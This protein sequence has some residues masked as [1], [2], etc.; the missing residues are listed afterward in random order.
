MKKII[1]YLVGLIGLF[2]VAFGIYN[3]FAS[4]LDTELLNESITIVSES[5][6]DPEVVESELNTEESEESLE[7]IELVKS[8]SESVTISQTEIVTEWQGP[9]TSFL[10]QD[11]ME[12]SLASNDG[13]PTLLNVWAT[14]CPPCRDEMPLFDENYALYGDE[15]NFIMLNALDSRPTETEEAALDFVEEMGLTFPIYFD[16]DFTNQVEFVANML[17]LT[18]LMDSNGEV[19]ETVR[20]QVSP[21]KLKQLLGKVIDIS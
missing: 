1:I 14:W 18:V 12:H 3:R 4:E 6:E 11:G 7:S 21:A 13:K 2:V 20:G 15:V 10:D 16:I 19:I 9:M 8:E 17:P 5:V